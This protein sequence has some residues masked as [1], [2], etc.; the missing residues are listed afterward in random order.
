MAGVPIRNFNPKYIDS[1]LDTIRSD[2]VRAKIK[3]VLQKTK[4]NEKKI[5]F[6]GFYF[7][8]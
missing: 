8:R 7:I 6:L 1:D 5:A 2:A 4:E 3:D